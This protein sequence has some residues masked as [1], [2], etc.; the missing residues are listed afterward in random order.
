MAD[1]TAKYAAVRDHLA[2]RIAHMAPGDQLS[3]EPVLCQEYGVSRITIR[4]AVEDLMRA[5][6]L[7]REQGRGTFVTEPQNVQYARESFADKVT[8]F[9]RQQVLLGRDVTTK[10]LANSVTRNPSA[11]RALGINSADELVE[12][13]RLR[14]V[15]G[16]L[17]QHVVTYLSHER[18]PGLL[19]HDFTVGSLFDH[20]ENTYDVVLARNDLLVRLEHVRPPLTA[21]LEVE[22]G[23]CVLAIESTVYDGADVAVAF[24]ITRNTPDNSEIAFSLRNRR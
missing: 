1:G 6:R 18:F 9:Y 8:G 3:T 12:L 20:L 23:E 5:G 22:D 21:V 16:V 17:H 19:A 15:N 14:Y 24:G 10:V 2:G 13:E 11:A 4:R 7:T